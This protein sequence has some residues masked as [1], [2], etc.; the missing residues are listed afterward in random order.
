MSPQPSQLVFMSAPLLARSLA[1]SAPS[2]ATLIHRSQ[3]SR[4]A[5]HDG[6]THSREQSKIDAPYSGIFSPPTSR[7]SSR[8]DN[9]SSQM[10]SIMQENSPDSRWRTV[11]GSDANRSGNGTSGRSHKMIL[12]YLG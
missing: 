8:A 1:K 2:R 6:P 9:R 4:R 7:R 10:V 12:K 11:S 5:L 3:R